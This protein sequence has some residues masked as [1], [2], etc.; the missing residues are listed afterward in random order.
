MKKYT[1]YDLTETDVNTI[2]GSLAEM[3]FKAVAAT[4]QKL[5]M[6][7]QPQINE[8]KEEISKTEIPPYDIS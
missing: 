3:P 8:Q 2:L 7:L 1:L 4:I 5:Q 6:Q